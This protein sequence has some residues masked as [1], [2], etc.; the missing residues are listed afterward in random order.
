MDCD[1]DES[2]GPVL[3]GPCLAFPASRSKLW[4]RPSIRLASS[5]RMSERR[6]PA[7]GHENRICQPVD[8]SKFLPSINSFGS[9]PFGTHVLNLCFEAIMGF[10]YWLS[11]LISSNLCNLLLWTTLRRVHIGGRTYFHS[12]LDWR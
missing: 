8:K 3:G 5:C 1:M 2:T 6:Q 12:N 10:H 11:F 9:S 4:I 7:I